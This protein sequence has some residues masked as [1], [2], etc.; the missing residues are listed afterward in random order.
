MS[1]A[2]EFMKYVCFDCGFVFGHLASWQEYR[3]EFWGAPCFETCCGCPKCHSEDV[4][5]VI[6]DDDRPK[7]SRRY[8]G[9]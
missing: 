7:K 6:K 2:T 5:E 4:E 1:A 9:T 3:G 8:I